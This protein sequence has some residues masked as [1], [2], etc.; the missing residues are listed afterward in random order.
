MKSLKEGNHIM[1]MG[2]EPDPDPPE[3]EEEEEED[4]EEE[5][6]EDNL[7]FKPLFFS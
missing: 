2:E 1:A 4:P 7:L 6:E 5:E 3:K